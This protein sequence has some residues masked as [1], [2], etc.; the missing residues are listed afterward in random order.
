MNEQQTT[1]TKNEQIV[2]I[3]AKLGIGLRESYDA[4]ERYGSAD[5]AIA[6]LSEPET[7]KRD[8]FSAMVAERDR[9]QQKASRYR[10]GLET[11]LRCKDDPKEIERAIKHALTF[12][13]AY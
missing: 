8:P 3:R 13:D 12:G 1:E 9:W 6:A 2:R 5:K 11:A 10:V 7:Q 4:F